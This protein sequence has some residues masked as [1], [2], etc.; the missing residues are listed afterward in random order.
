M[1][2]VILPQPLSLHWRLAMEIR[3]L[4]GHPGRGQD[5]TGNLSMN[6]SHAALSPL[7]EGLRSHNQH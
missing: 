4:S 5:P 1:L 3:Q 6:T 2:K 7:C